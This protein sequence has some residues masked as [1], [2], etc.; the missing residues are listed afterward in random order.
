MHV[1]NSWL[2]ANIFEKHSVPGYKIV[3]ALTYGQFIGMS[4]E[5][6]ASV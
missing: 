3:W 6:A 4:V 5:I 1:A 2:Q